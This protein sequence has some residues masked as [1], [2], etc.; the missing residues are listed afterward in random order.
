MAASTMSGMKTMLSSSQTITIFGGTGDLTYRKLLPAFYNL[1]NTNLLPNDFQIV[2]IGRRDYTNSTYRNHVRDWVI[3]HSRLHKDDAQLDV[4]LDHI[5]YFKMTF[6]DDEGYGRLSEYYQTLNPNTQHLYYF[7]VSPSFFETIAN[8][9]A[10]HDLINNSKVIIEKPF[11]NDLASSQKINDTLTKLFKESNIFRIDHYVAKEMI[12]NISTIRFT[13]EIFK[14]IWNNQ[15]IDNIQISANET[16]GVE[17]RGSYYDATG[18]LKDMF[19]NHILQIVSI[20]TMNE[21]KDSIAELIHEQQERILN[22]LFV[23]NY[24]KDVIFGQYSEND[25]SISYRDEESVDSDSTT[26]TFVSLK[27]G[28]DLPEWKGTPIYV[29]TGKRMHERDTRIS[30]VFKAENGGLQNVL[31]IKVQ[32]EEGV[33]LQ[34]N[35]KKPGQTYETQTVTMDF[36]QSCDYMNRVN[37]P[38]AY[39]RLLNA[40]MRGDHSLFTSFNQVKATWSFVEK[41][42]QKSPKRIFTYP[43]YTAGPKES[44]DLLES[45]SHYWVENKN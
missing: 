26:E 31:I 7:A 3:K 28:I 1:M 13:N 5:H 15:S 36:C 30:V 25:D 11:G 4:F 14:N 8:Q 32:P 43:A 10:K 33:Y 41:I 16:V 27:L 19:Q 34:F 20:V 45:N 12:Q 38:E 29:R 21:P 24:E 37:T 39:E 2:V 9:L 35:I 6:T 42:I 17:G 22:N 40:A 44:H 18:A 23:E